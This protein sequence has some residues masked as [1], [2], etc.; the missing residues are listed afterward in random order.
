MSVFISHSHSD[1]ALAACFQGHLAAIT[2]QGIDIHCSS[3]DG[4][5]EYGESWIDWINDKVTSAKITF[6]LLTPSSFSATWVLW[7]AGAVSG[8][9]R[10]LSSSDEKRRVIPIRFQIPATEGLGPFQTQQVADGLDVGE[11]E[12]LGD[13]VLECLRDDPIPTKTVNQNLRTLNQ[14]T[15]EFVLAAHEAMRELQIFKR[16]DVVQEWLSR[17]NQHLA[18]KDAQYVRSARRWINVA[19]LGVGHA[20][21]HETPVDFRLHLRLAQGFRLLK[22]WENARH[23]L[24]L[25]RQ[26]SPRDM[27]VLR[28]L[29]RSELELGHP[30][31]ALVCFN[32]MK[33]LDEGVFRSDPE[34]LNLF[35]RIL[36]TNADWQGAYEQL[37][38]A[39]KELADDTYV[40]NMLAIATAV[41]KGPSEANVHFQR[42]Q[43]LEGR[44]DG[45]SIW[46]IGNMV[47]AA[48]GT[49]DEANAREWLERLKD[50]PE[51][52]RNRD[53]I[54]RYFDTIVGTRPDFEFDWQQC[55]PS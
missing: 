49:G 21:S 13:I 51:A 43:A 38:S 12:E 7:E 35:V 40:V 9:Q 18:D 33:A 24:K 20:D 54:T 32:E 17:L 26:L 31:E 25:A 42:L 10:I 30:K 15:Q 47:N 46:S 3:K 52:N 44:D 48:L 4:S 45:K 27:M 2:S 36:I 39:G 22:E 1:A 5:I 11:M 19:F 34:A 16:E 23:Q 53:S 14:R 28:D 29:G 6:V 41:V 37:N 55:W 8:V 50:M